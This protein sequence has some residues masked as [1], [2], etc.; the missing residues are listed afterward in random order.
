MGTLFNQNV[1]IRYSVEK[2]EVE[3]FL[4]DIK[5]LSVR[6]KVSIENVLE[7]YKVKELERTTDLYVDNGDIHD[8]QMTGV[9]EL[10][11]ELIGAIEILKR[12]E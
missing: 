6:H 12:E 3:S 10:L 8:E 1:R 2:K 9:G 7:A 4:D 11:K 5:S